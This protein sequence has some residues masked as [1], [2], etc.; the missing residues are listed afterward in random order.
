[1][2]K[3]STSY[4]AA[5]VL[6]LLLL[7]VATWT[8][9]A[10]AAVPP[11][12]TGNPPPAH[13]DSTHGVAS[14]TITDC[15]A[16]WQQVAS[17][18]TADQRYTPFDIDALSSDD[19]WLVGNKGSYSDGKF[20]IQHW[21]GTEWSFSGQDLAEGMPGH[22]QSVA[23][24]APNNV[25]AAGTLYYSGPSFSTN[26]VALLLHWDGTQ[27]N[28]VQAPVPGN[29]YSSA[30]ADISVG[31]PDNIWAV[32]H[33]YVGGVLRALTIHW[34]GSQWTVVNVPG[35]DKVTLKAVSVRAQNDVWAV[36]HKPTDDSK[37]QAFTMHW[38]GTAWATVPVPDIE[39]AKTSLEGVVALSS[40]EVWAVGNK[41]GNY[42][43]APLMLHWDGQEW[44]EAGGLQS[45]AR[46]NLWDVV[47]L[48]PDDVW[49]AGTEGV[50][51]TEGPMILHWDGST[52]ARVPGPNVGDEGEFIWALSAISAGEIWGA[53]WLE[54]PGAGATETLV[55]RTSGDTCNLP[56]ETPAATAT[57]TPTPGSTPTTDLCAPTLERLDSPNNGPD[58]NTFYGVV[59]RSSN[60]VWAG[61][62]VGAIGGTPNRKA[63]IEHFDGAQWSVKFESAQ[64]SWESAIHDV[65]V[66]A[67]DDIWAAGQEIGENLYPLLHWDGNSW[68]EHTYPDMEAGDVMYAI[69][70]VSPDDVWAVGRQASKPKALHWDGSSWSAVPVSVP[71][72]PGTTDNKGAFQGLSATSADDVWAVGTADGLDASNTRKSHMLVAHWDGEAW[73]V[74]TLDPTLGAGTTYAVLQSVSAL[75]PDNVW[76]AGWHYASFG[77]YSPRPFL[78][79]WDGQTWSTQA[80]P[81]LP[82]ASRTAL[83]GL[84]A[85]AD[86]DVWAVG[87][88][89]GDRSIR[90]LQ[91]FVLHWDGAAWEIVPSLGPGAEQIYLESVAATR[92]NPGEIWMVGTADKAATGN[93][94]ALRL[95][96]PCVV[97]PATATPSPTLTGTATNTSTSTATATATATAT[98]TAEDTARSTA[99]TSQSTGT[100]AS[101]VSPASTATATIAASATACSLQFADLPPGSTFQPFA[102]C[103]A[104]K[105]IVSGYDCGG[106]GEPCHGQNNPY[107]RPG[108]LITRGQVAK[109]VANGLGLAG[110]PGTQ[111]FEDVPPGATFYSYVN[112][113]A[114]L[115]VMGGYPCGSPGETCGEGNLPYFRPD[116]HATRGQ[117][118]KIV[119][120]AAGYAEDHTAQT[121]EDVPATHTFYL[122]VERL[123]SRAVMGGYACGSPGELC[124][125]ANLPYFRP[126]ATA[127]RG[128]VAKIVANTFF[129]ECAAP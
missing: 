101:P 84:A 20:F 54:T 51:P 76:A 60:D 59:P 26:H 97:P 27:W 108:K 56:T 57:Q 23:A 14:D 81:T 49:A 17:L 28:T 52:W 10:R 104:C 63:K 40:G 92:D 121:F 67:P 103:L 107:F 118:A 43:M 8:T 18:D 34:D 117:I 119:S 98:S 3:K 15:V 11:R 122:P 21:D 128:Q 125:Q 65:E 114:A 12:Q 47:A 6:G 96:R 85:V 61:G 91:S 42:P 5:A 46:G 93:T 72:V 1:V 70:A 111:L 50:T 90:D 110:A 89:D 39:A 109:I 9:A 71:A 7:A 112:R 22:L 79:H 129:E 25:W 123:A 55:M 29:S 94:L 68:T 69:H 100:P 116:E 78:M 64:V 102:F 77:S 105:G 126:N 24:V 35:G 62:A 99:T 82:Y 45:A 80:I 44:H 32:G 124:G 58:R 53:G 74:S 13:S 87:T 73:S 115:G 66:L 75:S 16:V 2:P 38:D 127:T 86:D 106:P 4:V 41:W 31:A 95:T 33:A 113:L 48:S 83:F 120:N 88:T 19:V 37:S 36:G 30:L